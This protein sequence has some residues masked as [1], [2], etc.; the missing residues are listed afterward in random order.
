MLKLN[1]NHNPYLVVAVECCMLVNVTIV[2]M[3]DVIAI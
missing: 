3:V 2:V 1:L